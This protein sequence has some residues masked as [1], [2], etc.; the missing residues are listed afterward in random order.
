MRLTDSIVALAQRAHDA[1]HAGDVH[2]GFAALNDLDAAVAALRDVRDRIALLNLPAHLTATVIANADPD[3]NAASPAVISAAAA[4]STG[5]QDPALLA[6]AAAAAAIGLGISGVPSPAAP[7]PVDLQVPQQFGATHH[8]PAFTPVIPANAAVALQRKRSRTGSPSAARRASAAAASVT[9]TTVGSPLLDASAANNGSSGASLVRRSSGSSRSA[10]PAP[11]TSGSV[12]GGAHS[13]S[14]ALTASASGSPA[15]VTSSSFPASAFPTPHAGSL[16]SA[17]LS[18]VSGTHQFA[19]HHQFQNPMLGAALGHVGGGGLATASPNPFVPLPADD[20]PPLSL[21]ALPMPLLGS[22]S[23]NGSA[24]SLVYPASTLAPMPEECEELMDMSGS[25]AHHHAAAALAAAANGTCDLAWLANAA[26]ASLG[27]LSAMSFGSG[28]GTGEYPSS[29]ASADSSI[30]G[31][32]PS[33]DGM[34]TTA[35]NAAA[36][37]DPH[38]FLGLGDMSA[39]DGFGF[40]ALLTPATS[41]SL[42]SLILTQPTPTEAWT[43]PA[44]GHT[45]SPLPFPLPTPPAAALGTSMPA[46][47]SPAAVPP[48]SSGG[49]KLA[50]RSS[51]TRGG[52]DGPGSSTAQTGPGTVPRS[53]APKI[54]RSNSTTAHSARGAGGAG[55]L[56]RSSST[57]SRASAATAAAAVAAAAAAKAATSS[58]TPNESPMTLVAPPARPLAPATAST[59]PLTSAVPLVTAVV[60]RVADLR[61][62]G[63]RVP[64]TQIQQHTTNSAPSQLPAEAVGELDRVFFGFLHALCADPAATDSRGDPIHQTQA[65]RLMEAVAA[66]A[67]SGTEDDAAGAPPSVAIEATDA[68]AAGED[69]LAAGQFTVISFRIQAFTTAF[70]EALEATGIGSEGAAD[71][72]RFKLSPRK[73]RVYLWNNRFIRRFIEGG[74]KAKTKGAHIWSVRARKRIAAPVAAVPTPGTLGGLAHDLAQDLR[75][76][77]SP[78]A[79]AAPEAATAW[80]WEFAPFERK[81]VGPLPPVAVPGSTGWTWE[82]S[83]W[84]PQ[85]KAPRAVF[86]SPAG[87]LPPWLAWDRAGAVLCGDPPAGLAPGVREVEVVA[88]YQVG[89][90]QVTVSKLVEIEVA[91]AVSDPRV[92]ASSAGVAAAA[93]AVAAAGKSSAAAA[94][95]ASNTATAGWSLA[96]GMPGYHSHVAS[97]MGMPPIPQLPMQMNMSMPPP[98]LSYFAP[99]PPPSTELDWLQQGAAGAAAVSRP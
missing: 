45:A 20:L 92:L 73:I 42:P 39:F 72:G 99:P 48:P 8:S 83:I 27:D 6:T 70:T 95:S 60:A 82:P 32:L 11:S 52:S 87:S 64:A 30:L 5:T 98:P 31:F 97:L 41:A 23:A 37:M 54:Q 50:R 85:V 10:R 19:H 63:I 80:E 51:V 40:D 44:A 22:T 68:A 43:L 62:R 78:P 90:T 1:L 89:D 16:L 4:A 66:P 38:Q 93:A 46:L 47:P 14:P 53:S 17:Q 7:A 21:S 33:F 69:G 91:C 28:P 35:A 77:D 74:K 67:S 61:A 88:R 29:L 65:A 9:G 81:I 13:A 49:A 26:G 18:A 34:D 79:P 57:N 96:A 84:D 15:S 76:S 12:S 58:T 94:V 86:E 24:T 75:L 2:A 36:P 25:D 3:A 56:A 59:A 55:G 71:G